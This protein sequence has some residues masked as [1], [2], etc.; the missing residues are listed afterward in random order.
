MTR[1]ILLGGIAALALSAGT[2]LPA[3]A[4]DYDDYNNY[5]TQQRYYD[6]DYTMP[7][8][9][10]SD[11]SDRINNVAVET[12]SGTYVGEVRSVRTNFQGEPSRIGIALRNGRWV[13]LD[14][15]DARYDPSRNI[16]RSSLSYDQL[17]DMSI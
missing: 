2:A 9:N 3:M 6:E 8:R 5:G 15:Q 13:W 10:L 4:Q 11:A 17:E 7:L 1:K 14:A 16:V 12:P